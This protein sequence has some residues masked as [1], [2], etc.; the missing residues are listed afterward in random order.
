MGNL[1]RGAAVAALLLFAAACGD[2]DDTA[3]PGSSDTTAAA[4]DGSAGGGDACAASGSGEAITI[5]DFA[6]DPSDVTVASGGVVT[7]T[8]EDGAAHTF[9]SD[10][11]GFDCDVAGGE[12]VNVQVDAPAGEY[13]FHCDIHPA[14]TGTIA[15]E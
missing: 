9:T 13:E 7:L 10:D 5:A 14:M 3:D 11:G 4:E 6:F 2:D 8:N 15:V 1:T 12:S